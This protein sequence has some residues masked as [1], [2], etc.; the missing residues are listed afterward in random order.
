MQFI[1]KHIFTLIRF[2]SIW[3]TVFSTYNMINNKG[4]LTINVAT[5]TVSL[6]IAILVMIAEFWYKP[7]D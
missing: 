2:L 5:L 4:N 3:L 1:K 6:T 7:K